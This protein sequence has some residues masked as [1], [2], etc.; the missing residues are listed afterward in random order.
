MRA[1]DKAL[2]GRCYNKITIRRDV[3]IKNR[4]L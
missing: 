3:S 2:K 1:F 4:I